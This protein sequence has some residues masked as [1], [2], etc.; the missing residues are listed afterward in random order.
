MRYSVP[1]ECRKRSPC[2]EVTIRYLTLF[3]DH[4]RI[5]QKCVNLNLTGIVE[6]RCFQHFVP[7]R[8]SFQAILLDW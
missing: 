1:N 6:V 4:S 7:N 5:T 8:I 2:R 3:H